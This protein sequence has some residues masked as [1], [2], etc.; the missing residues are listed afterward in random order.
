MEKTYGKPIYFP[1]YRY[2]PG[3]LRVQQGYLVKFPVELFEVIAGIDSALGAVGSSVIVEDRAGRR[4]VAR[5]EV[6]GPARRS[7]QGALTRVQDPE[8]R[9]AIENHA[10]DT[11]I[12]FYRAAGAT[13]VV[14]LGKP[15]DIKLRIDDSELHV[16]VKG[17]SMLIDTVELTINEVRHAGDHQPTDLVVVDD[18]DW[19]RVPAGI[20]TSGGRFRRWSGWMPSAEDLAPTRYAYRLPHGSD[21]TQA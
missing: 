6:R 12:E 10:V 2:G 8:L 16:E 15:Y 11:A 1:F 19:Q 3:E 14:R 21:L 20:E 17:S 4:Q 9:A 5:R 7:A 13:D 18:I